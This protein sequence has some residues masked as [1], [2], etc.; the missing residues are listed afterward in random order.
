MGRKKYFFIL[1]YLIVI[2]N[3][4]NCIDTIKMNKSF[5]VYVELRVI[6]F[7]LSFKTF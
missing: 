3:N 5:I 1:F 4:D 2:T 6:N 7:Q